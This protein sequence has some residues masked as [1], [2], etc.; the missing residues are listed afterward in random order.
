M[1]AITGAVVLNHSDMKDK[2]YT[3]TIKVSGVNTDVSVKNTESSEAP[4]YADIYTTLSIA[5]N[6]IIDIILGKGTKEMKDN[7]EQR[8]V[9]VIDTE[10]VEGWKQ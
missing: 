6:S 9:K 1:G 10:T 7:T 2:N 8:P 3:I 5:Q 4:T